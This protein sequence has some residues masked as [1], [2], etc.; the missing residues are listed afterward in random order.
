MTDEG[1]TKRKL[2]SADVY[3]NGNRSQ[4]TVL[5]KTS[6]GSERSLQDKK[7]ISLCAY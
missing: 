2:Y 3:R 4:S 1:I 5:W 6:E 7:S